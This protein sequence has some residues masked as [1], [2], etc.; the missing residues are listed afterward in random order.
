MCSTL[1]G[2]LKKILDVAQIEVLS[3]A[4]ILI[5]LGASY[6]EYAAKEELI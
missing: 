1:L 3:V 2:W 4:N 5:V 6:N